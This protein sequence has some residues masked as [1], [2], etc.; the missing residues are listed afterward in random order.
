VI[1]FKNFVLYISIYMLIQCSL[2][3]I[4]GLIIGTF[5]FMSINEL[6]KKIMDFKRIR[7]LAE[8]KILNKHI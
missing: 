4:G 6:I 1:I 8:N 5:L 7:R 3:W 2:K